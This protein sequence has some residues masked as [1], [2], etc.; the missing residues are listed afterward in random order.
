MIYPYSSSSRGKRLAIWPFF[1]RP[2]PVEVWRCR[3]CSHDAVR[4]YREFGR[5]LKARALGVEAMLHVCSHCTHKQ[6]L[7]ELDEEQLAPVYQGMFTTAEERASYAAQYKQPLPPY[8]G[9]VERIVQIAGEL[10]LPQGARTHEFGCG[11]GILV[12]HLRAAGFRA[13]GSDWSH[14]AVA[15]AKEQGNEHVFPEDSGTPRNLK[16]ENID[17]VLALHVI[18]HI[19]DPVSSLRQL[20][21]VLGPRSVI[22]LMTNQGDGIVNREH[23]MFFDSW[24]YFPQHLHY[25]SA[26]SFMALARSAGCKVLRLGTTNRTF[27]Q[28]EAALGPIAPGQSREERLRET[29]RRFQNQE[30]EMVLAR[31]D[32]VLEEPRIELPDPAPED[33]MG[34][35]PWDSHEDFFATRSQWRRLVVKR[36]DYSHVVDMVFSDAHDYWYWG[37][38]FVG[39]HWLAHYD[40]DLLPMLAFEAPRAGSYR[41][42]LRMGIRHEAEPPCQVIVTRPDAAPA[43]FVIDHLASR[44]RSYQ[45][46]MRAKERFGVILRA[47]RTPNTQKAICLVAVRSG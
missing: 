34:P 4:T 42:E 20:A 23:G 8:K 36:S 13:T 30:M 29:T 38:A 46:T 12:H 21:S 1:R 9:F 16:D 6:Y 39:D 40:D 10:G 14:A 24:F 22:V 5:R 27:P 15:F 19:P 43:T 18:E 26:R 17:I 2:K 7:P 31:D 44:R 37:P 41:F 33:S 32:S 28:V 11:A 3:I 25:F 47:T 35:A 45:V